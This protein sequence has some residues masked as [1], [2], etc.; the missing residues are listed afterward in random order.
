MKLYVG[1]C[2]RCGN[3][4]KCHECRRCGNCDDL[5]HSRVMKEMS[6]R[7][8]DRTAELEAEVKALRD[9]VRTAYLLGGHHVEEGC[10]QYCDSGSAE[11]AD[12]IIT[13]ALQDKK[14]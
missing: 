6:D 7:Y 3:D 9:A 13:E 10:H 11:M 2:K 8:G 1:L 4:A 5:Y 12:E 14:G